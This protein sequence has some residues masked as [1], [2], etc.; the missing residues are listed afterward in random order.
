MGYG[1]GGTETGYTG[2]PI[3]DAPRQVSTVQQQMQGLESRVDSLHGL[4]SELEA[5]IGSVLMPEPPK[6]LSGSPST[7]VGIG[8][9]PVPLG[10]ELARRNE[11]LAAAS[12]RLRELIDRIEL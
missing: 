12:M 2:R 7:Q 3:T 1:N 6:A 11:T 5:R 8:Y 4:I 9:P 10:G